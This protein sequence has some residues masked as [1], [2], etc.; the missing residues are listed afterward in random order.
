LQPLSQTARNQLRRRVIGV[1]TVRV[2]RLEQSI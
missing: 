1:L 2:K